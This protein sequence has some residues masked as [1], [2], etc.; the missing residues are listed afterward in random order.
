MARWRSPTRWPTTA[1]AIPSMRSARRRG[2]RNQCA[3]VR[4]PLRAGMGT[5]LWKRRSEATP[6]TS[7]HRTSPSANP[8]EVSAPEAAVLVELKRLRIEER[9]TSTRTATRRCAR[10]VGSYHPNESGRRGHLRAQW[11]HPDAANR[12][13][14]PTRRPFRGF[15]RHL[16]D[17][18]PLRRVRLVL[19]APARPALG[20]CSLRCGRPLDPPGRPRRSG[21]SRGATRAVRCCPR[22]SR[23]RSAFT[24][25]HGPDCA[26]SEGRHL[27]SRLQTGENLLLFL[28]REPRLS[29]AGVETGGECVARRLRERTQ[30]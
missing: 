4:E 7:R 5:T 17:R 16:L 11:L 9:L 22:V 20:D 27:R 6:A 1:H 13:R 12:P 25:P 2:V 24:E 26:L 28:A 8:V 15:E 10:D 30:G 18:R 23:T 29:L 3:N 19:A 14:G 21:G